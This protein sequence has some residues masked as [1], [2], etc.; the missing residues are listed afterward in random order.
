MPGVRE[1]IEQHHYAEAETEAARLAEVL[2]R[3]VALID[4][5]SHQ[6]ESTGGQGTQSGQ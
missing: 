4:S 6:L 1:N 3:E 2:K 5:A